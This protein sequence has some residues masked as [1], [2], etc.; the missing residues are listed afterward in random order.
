MVNDLDV[1]QE[2]EKQEE[3]E[4]DGERVRVWGGGGV[5]SRQPCSPG[6]RQWTSSTLMQLD[7]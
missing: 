6:P 5:C 7:K 4:E 2:E 1:G 3:T